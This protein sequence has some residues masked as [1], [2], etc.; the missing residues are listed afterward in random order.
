M[1]GHVTFSGQSMYFGKSGSNALFS[2]S[3][4]YPNYGIWYHE[5]NVDKMSFSAS[6]N[7]HSISSADLCINGNGD[8]TVTIRGNTI[9]HAGNISG[10]FTSLTR[11]SGTNDISIT[12]GGTTKTITLGSHAW[13]STSYA[14]SSHGHTYLTP[15]R[16]ESINDL[17]GWEMFTGYNISGGLGESW[18]HGIC[19]LP[20]D[21]HNG[22]RHVLAFYPYATDADL[23]IKTQSGG[24]WG[25][26]RKLLTDSNYTSYTVKKDGTGASGTWG[27]SITGSASTATD[28]TKVLKAGDTM[29]GRLN[30]NGNSSCPLFI[31]GGASGYQHGIVIKSSNAWS[32]VLLGDDGVSATSGA[33]SGSYWVGNNAGKFCISKADAGNSSVSIYCDGSNW[34]ANTTRIVTNS[35]TWGISI[36]GNAA[37]ATSAGSATSADKLNFERVSDIHATTGWKVFTTTNSSP[38]NGPSAKWM[39]GITFLPNNDT[40]GYRNILAFVDCGSEN[41]LWIQTQGAGSWGSWR[42]VLTTGNFVAGT[43]YQAPI[44][45]NTYHPYGG[46][47]LSLSATNIYLNR[48]GANSYGRISFYSSSYVTWF[49]YMTPAGYASP[50]GKNAPSG[51]YVTSWAI[52][53]LIENSGGY[54]WTWESCTNST[55]STPAL[56]M[57]LSSNTGNLKVY[58]NIYSD[59]SISC[60]TASDKNL[61]DNIT[62]L[63]RDIAKS[64]IMSSRPVSYT[65][66]KKATSLDSHL[67]GEDLGLVAQ[68]AENIL[69]QAISPIWNKYKRIDYTKFIA[70][71]IKVEQDH[72]ERIQ[73][74]ENSGVKSCFNE[75]YVSASDIRLKENISELNIHKV[76][77][78]LRQLKPKKFNWNSLALELDPMKDKETTHLGYIA[79]E[80]EK[81]IPSAV[82]DDYFE[83]YKRLNPLEIIPLLHAAIVYILEKLQP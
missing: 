46:G 8:G 78:I 55:S 68:E 3:A 64:I 7:A 67:K 17:S 71:I 60:G 21:D 4:D 79:Q 2:Y 36:T 10:I 61:K 1:T 24:S 35:G 11:T 43:N 6:G 12:V 73:K 15:H 25:S 44:A 30:I 76:L 22:Y 83:V 19:V 5:E 40:N 50:T 33:T 20:N 75:N 54:G 27:I 52:R 56:K 31:Y 47:E 29:T 62:S 14:A 58:G 38:S 45:A 23:Y 65:W 39:Q 72:E 51:S 32:G 82:T 48:S 53:C 16:I 9:Y 37:T 34:Y 63:D 42:K 26:W 74:L 18:I 41:D 66:N 70:P 80:V 57:E 28:S 59:G 49:F 77:N 81:L 69:P 13:D